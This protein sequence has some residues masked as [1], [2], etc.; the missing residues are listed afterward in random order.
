MSLATLKKRT[1]TTY[2]RLSGTASGGGFVVNRTSAG[3]YGI[4]FK[5]TTDGGGFSINGSRRNISTT[6]KSMAIS[7]NRQTHRAVFVPGEGLHSQPKGYG[8]KYG[9]YYTTTPVTEICEV[10]EYSHPTVMNTRSLLT[11]KKEQF[12]HNNWVQPTGDTHSQGDYIAHT[13]ATRIPPNY[14]SAGLSGKSCQDGSLVTCGQG[15]NHITKDLGYRKASDYTT[16]RKRVDATLPTVQYRKPWPP[17]AV[18]S[19]VGCQTRESIEDFKTGAEKDITLAKTIF[20]C[21]TTS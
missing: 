21:D 17:R 12:T 9:S 10:T 19:G 1:K 2:R 6:G 4:H 20:A 14:D 8:G 7:Q 11:L 13:I 3:N 5:A 15:F 16:Y 18:D